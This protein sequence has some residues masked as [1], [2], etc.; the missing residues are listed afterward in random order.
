MRHPAAKG[1]CRHSASQIVE[2]LARVDLA[3]VMGAVGMH[4]AYG[5]RMA[6]DSAAASDGAIS[7]EHAKHLARIISAA[8][9]Y[10]P[11]EQGRSM[12]IEKS[13]VVCRCVCCAIAPCSGPCCGL[14]GPC[15]FPPVAAWKQP[16]S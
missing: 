16:P 3:G 13:A 1:W 7:E 12:F 4:I 11:R 10:T 8:L 5:I 9:M 14:V 2:R 6:V 15:S